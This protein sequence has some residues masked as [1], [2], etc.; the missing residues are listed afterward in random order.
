MG[1]KASGYRS[2]TALRMKVD[3]PHSGEPMTAIFTTE[4]RL[5]VVRKSSDQNPGGKDMV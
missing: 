2:F 4:F 5:E 1:G 3:L